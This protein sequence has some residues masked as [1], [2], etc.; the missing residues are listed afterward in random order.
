MKVGIAGAGAIG[1][2]YAALLASRGHD[3]ILWSPRG[4]RVRPDADSLRVRTAGVLDT[5]ADVQVVHDAA[6]LAKADALVICVLGN[7]HRAVMDSLAPHVRPG[8]TV[9]VSS[10]ASLGAL[11]LS[12][13]LAARGCDAPILAWATTVTG[14]P[15]RDG[16]V[17]VRMLRNEMDVAAI[18]V[19]GLD[20]GL[21][22]S[23]TLFGDRF[24]AAP[25]LLAIT[26]SNLNPPIHMANAL[27]NYTR[28][29]FGETW[30]NYGC[31]TPGV[32]RLIEALDAERLAVAAAFGLTVRSVV[33]HYHKT[34]DDLP[35]GQGVSALAQ[36][37]ESRRKGSSPGPAT[38]HH[39]FLTEDLPFGI[40]AVIAI[41]RVAGIPVPMHEAGLAL[42]STAYGRDFR[43]DND[44]LPPL[45][46]PAMDAGSLHARCKL[47]WAGAG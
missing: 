24:V 19:S 23:R 47:G 9:I 17:Q 30:A 36:I 40:H 31:I 45:D 41:A 4:S 2:G 15:I 5:E 37:V 27:L 8:Q 43:A 44:L 3:P 34:F 26:L 11:Y 21:A 33:E 42:L 18:P 39:R 20:A 1:Q 25:D 12:R 7:G 28:M 32:G 14:G 13:L 38:V 6:E 16:V 46:L 22:L 10:H 35:D 29:E